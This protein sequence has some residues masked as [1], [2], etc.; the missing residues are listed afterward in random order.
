VVQSG[1][2]DSPNKAPC[3]IVAYMRR[4]LKKIVLPLVGLLE[5]ALD[6]KT[7]P[8]VPIAE[9][10]KMLFRR[11]EPD[12]TR[13]ISKKL[14]GGVAFDIGANVG[15]YA[16]LMAPHV[17]HV[18]AFEPDPDNFAILQKNCVRHPT[19]TPLNMA[20]GDTTGVVDFYK[21]KDSAMR[22]SLIDEG[23]TLKLSV[24][25]TTLD[26]FVRERGLQGITLIKIDVEGAESRVL[27]GMHEL[28]AREQPTVVYEGADPNAQ[29]I[30]KNGELVSYAE[31]PRLGAKQK[32]SNLVINP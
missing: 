14:R 12:T 31:A 6:F 21:V 28:L 2:R 20:V 8:I 17:S 11:Y 15:Y 23:G 3:A 27:A 25:C 7:S 19:I 16:R 5:V 1:L 30:G 26:T 29:A 32:V 10:L 13:F 18:F 4:V 24:S 22:H 9:R